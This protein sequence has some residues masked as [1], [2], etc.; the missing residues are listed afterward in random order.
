MIKLLFKKEKKNE[1]TTTTKEKE[2]KKS[3]IFSKPKLALPKI[4]PQIMGLFFKEYDEESGI[5]KIDDNHYS[6]CFQYTDISFSKADTERQEAIFLRYVDFLN[7]NSIKEHIQVVHAG[8]IVETEEY[9]NRFIFQEDKDFTDNEKRIASEFNKLIMNVIGH[10]KESLLETRLIV[11][12][13]EADSLDE[14]K[15]LFMEYQIRLEEKFKGFGSTI[16]RWNINQ[17]LEFLYNIFNINTLKQDYPEGQKILDLVNGDLNVYDILSPKEKISF[18]EKN[19]I[20]IGE[21]EKK[22][23]IKILY[24]DKLPKS[25]TPEFYNKLTTEIKDANIIVTEN[26]T[27][28]D[29]A[30]TIKMLDKKISGMQT[31]R[32]QK[33]K[34]ANKSGYDYSVVSNPKFEEQLNDALALRTALTK[35]KQK[36]FTK[37]LLVCIISDDLK[38]LNRIAQEI[39][40][41]ASE[42]ICTMRPLD[43]QQLEGLLNLLPFGHNTLQ[44]QRSLTSEAAATSVPF[45]TKQLIHD[46]SIFYGLD[47]VSKNIVM[48]D[49]KKLINGNGVVLATSGSGKSFFVKMMIEQILL[50][51]PQDD[52]LI[53]DYQSE[54]AKLI[55]AYNGQTIKLSTK[56]DSFINPFDISINYQIDDEDPIKAKMEYVLAFVE[57]LV[58]GSGLT[59]EQKSII[60]RCSKTLYEDYYE[61][62]DDP[63]YEPDFPKFYNILKNFHEPEAEN[64]ALIIER[65]VKGGSD[66]FSHHTNIEI[67]NRLVSFDLSSMPQ[68]MRTTSYM[69]ILEHIMNRL[70][71]NQSEGKYTWIFVDEFHIMLANKYSAD[72]IEKIYRIGRKL[73]AL[74]TVITQKIEDVLKCEQG[75]SI[76]SNSE[77]AAI[78]KQKQ[79]DL[80]AISKM[81]GISEE[82]Q[83]YI[84]DPAHG[85]GLIVYDHDIIPIRLKVPEDYYIYELNQTSNMQKS[86]D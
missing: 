83:E 68:S 61:H 77:F 37:N 64:L 79:L 74:P 51:Y 53:V 24:L 69:V 12:S 38:E 34:R 70:T 30:K 9:K 36:L 5:M 31:E 76:L 8:S 82:E 21:G 56:T 10:Q 6:V 33:V 85:E 40:K 22:K 4:T 2:K 66:I 20:S 44:F 80:P 54:Y 71:K 57:S 15:D 23:Y 19:Y 42:S 86:R 14:A 7:S 62:Q 1:L 84:I 26:I 11:I 27:P 75:R 73:F 72:Y 18:R 46:K 13:T 47:L 35:K 32:L 49:R 16:T 52:I 17:R 50:R 41:I 29:P 59:G 65:Y 43:W 67:K 25:I 3:S 63:A 48:C 28:T 55:N 78:F 81:F 45:N 58:G 60:D 39:N